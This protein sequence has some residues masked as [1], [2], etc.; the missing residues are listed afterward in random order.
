M[1]PP[2]RHRHQ[3]PDQPQNRQARQQRGTQEGLN[4]PN[5]V[6]PRGHRPPEPGR[7]SAVQGP[8]LDCGDSSPLSRRETRHPP[9]CGSGP[10]CAH[11]TDS[12][13]ANP[14]SSPRLSPRIHGDRGLD[15]PASGRRQICQRPGPLPNRRPGQ[16]QRRRRDISVA[17]AHSL[18]SSPVRGDIIPSPLA[19]WVP[20]P[21][22][23]N[24]PTRGRW[25]GASRSPK[26]GP[27]TSVPPHERQHHNRQSVDL[28]PRRP[29]S[30]PTV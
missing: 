4:L 7:R 18:D 16:R 6:A 23:M 17:L 28:R 27:K 19:Q 1:L 29:S 11:A 12:T 22:T 26:P 21:R 3:G 8:P 5:L 24:P 15:P 2:H 9:G 25:H 13:P 10:A 30:K 14:L 20:C